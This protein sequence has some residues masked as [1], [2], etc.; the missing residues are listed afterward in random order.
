MENNNDIYEGDFVIWKL[1]E[2]F[3]DAII[4]ETD[5]EYYRKMK[6]ISRD[7]TVL[8]VTTEGKVRDVHWPKKKG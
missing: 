8:V 1:K 5:I 3:D 6:H 4:T 7:T 2:G